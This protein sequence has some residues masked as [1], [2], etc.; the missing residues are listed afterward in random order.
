M[1]AKTA[2]ILFIII[3]VLWLTAYAVYIAIQNA[4]HKRRRAYIQKRYKNNLSRIK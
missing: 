4:K 2:G 3:F 1:D